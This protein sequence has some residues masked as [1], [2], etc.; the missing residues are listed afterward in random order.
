MSRHVSRREF[1][2]TILFGTLIAGCRPVREGVP[3]IYAP[4]S[5]RPPATPTIAPTTSPTISLPTVANTLPDSLPITDIERLYVK[6]FRTTPEIDPKAHT[7]TLDGLV[8]QPLTLTMDEIVAMP[9]ITEMR[10][11]Q[12]ISNP[13]G[14]GLIGN[15]VWRGTPLRPILDRLG[16]LESCRYI[17]FEAADGYTTSVPLERL[18]TPPIA[19]VLLIYEANG[20]PLPPDH[21]YPLRILIPGLYGQ[22]QPKWIIRMH[23]AQEDKLGYWEGP[24][25]EWSNVATVKT[26]S[27]IREPRI[28]SNPPSPIRIAGS[29]F[30]GSRAITAVDVSVTPQAQNG[31]R[32]WRPAILIA[33]SSPLVW[34]WYV[35]DWTPPAAG[36][37][38]VAVRALD[39]TGFTQTRTASNVLGGAFPDG[40][41][42][43][44][45]TTLTIT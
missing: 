44:H 22:K 38:T 15:I 31:E 43:I 3:T 21:G 29:A 39:E 19:D 8:R 41:D 27:Q 18:I 30:A 10:T 12:C 34:T 7:L 25:W 13:V 42:A 24:A 37:Y 26:N 23:F 20:A 16:I 32:D 17:H 40:T 5:T 35:F 2:S 1:L 14:G 11:L 36:V 45:E 28:R 33:P 4:G 9:S 6:S